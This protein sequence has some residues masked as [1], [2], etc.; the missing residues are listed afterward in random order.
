MISGERTTFGAEVSEQE[1]G[2]E[3]S[4]MFWGAGLCVCVCVCRRRTATAK[5]TRQTKTMRNKR[6]RQLSAK[7]LASNFQ[8]Q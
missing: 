7:G 3:S 2:M 1:Q 4:Q 5:P 8:D 6:L